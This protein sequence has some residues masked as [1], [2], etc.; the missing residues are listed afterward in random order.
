MTSVSGLEFDDAWRTRVDGEI[1]GVRVPI[2]GLDSF[3]ANK[4]A[5]G[6]AK[7]LADLELLNGD[8]EKR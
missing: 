8:R 6:R 2:L 7:D 3:I 4:R 1:E 5:S